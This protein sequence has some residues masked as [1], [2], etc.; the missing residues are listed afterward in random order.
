MKRTFL[1]ATEALCKYK[2]A[3]AERVEAMWATMWPDAAQAIAA[4]TDIEAV[5]D[6]LDTE[7]GASEAG[8]TEAG[9]PRAD[10]EEAT[11]PSLAD[12]DFLFAVDLRGSDRGADR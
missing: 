11:D 10:D 3:P 12:V 1:E 6:T 5:M 8:T 7:S 4:Q 2:C 9:A